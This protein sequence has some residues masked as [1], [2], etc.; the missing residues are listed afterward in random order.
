MDLVDHHGVNLAVGDVGEQP[1]QDG[2]VHVAA[3]EAAIVIE[4]GQG[5]PTFL[6]LAFDIGL[7]G[8]ALGVQGVEVLV[9]PF[10]R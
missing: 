4:G 3:G 6:L 7:A 2:P 10:L 9:Q 1:P 8:F 5:N